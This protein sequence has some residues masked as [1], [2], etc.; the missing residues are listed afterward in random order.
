MDTEQEIWKILATI[1]DPEIPVLSILDL[2]IVRNVICKD[3][4]TVEVI[5][6]PTYVGC[7]AMDVIATEIRMNLLQLGIKNIQITTA[8][9]P[10]WTTDWMT[11][12]GK[13]KL[14][15]YGIAPPRVQKAAHQQ[16][17]LFIEEESVPC[18]LCSSTNTHL[19][20][21]F[22]STACKALYQCND[23]KEPFDY[24]KC[25]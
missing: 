1:N 16:N 6:T 18:P 4:K 9:S 8:L 20:S 7:P 15:Q 2:G 19:I 12:S 14:K 21:Q 25:H 5:I 24:F 22:G 3:D 23:C 17:N 11:E 10:A 13:Q